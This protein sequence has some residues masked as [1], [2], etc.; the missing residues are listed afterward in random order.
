MAT[1]GDEF[2][3]GGHETLTVIRGAADTGGEVLEVEAAWDAGAEQ[4]P[5]HY[6]PAQD[7]HFEVLEGALRATVDGETR[8]Y[9]AGESFDIPR[10]ARHTLQPDGGPARARWE[11]RRRS[12]RRTGSPRFRARWRRGTSFPASAHRCC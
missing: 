9:A 2:R 5:S 7:E 12:E 3:L 6:H 8:L 1:A 10:G 11:T 4:P